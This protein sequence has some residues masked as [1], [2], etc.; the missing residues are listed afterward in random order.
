MAWET[1]SMAS[2]ERVDVEECQDL[3]GFEELEGGQ[4][5]CWFVLARGFD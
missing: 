4:V 1:Y 5:S 3:V 2:G